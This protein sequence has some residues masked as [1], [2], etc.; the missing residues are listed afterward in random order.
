M[1]RVRRQA[2]DINGLYRAYQ[3]ATVSFLA[4]NEEQQTA[5]CFERLYRAALD[6]AG[7]AELPLPKGY[8]VPTATALNYVNRVV[9]GWSQAL[10]A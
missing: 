10:A 5:V 3:A 2:P 6:A 8:E 1:R 4:L 7:F 9:D